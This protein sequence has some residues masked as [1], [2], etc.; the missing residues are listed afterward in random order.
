MLKRLIILPLLFASFLVPGKQI[1]MAISYN[2]FMTPEQEGYVELY[3]ALNSASLDYEK[4]EGGFQS[5][6]EVTI[7]IMQDSTFITGDKFRILSPLYKD[8]SS[9][10]RVLV[11]QQRYVLDSGNYSFHFTIQDIVEEEERHNLSQPIEVKIKREDVFCS[12]I[13]L[14]DDFHKTTEPTA[15]SKSG[16]DLV[17]RITSGTHYLPSGVNEL[18]FYAELYNINQQVND[19]EAFL[20]R[21]YLTDAQSGQVKNSYASFAKKDAQSVVPVLA[22][23]NIKNLPT[24]NYHLTI[25]ASDREGKELWK[26]KLF[27]YRRNPRQIDP[28]KE[29][30]NVDLQQTFA[31]R[32]TEFDSI[33]QY[34]EYLWPIS[35]EKQRNFQ[36]HLLESRDK[37][38]MQKYFYSFWQSQD[39]NNP[40]KA[41]QNYHQKIKKVNHS[42]GTRL[43]PGYMTD[44]GRVYLTYGAPYEIAR[45]QIEPTVPPYE[46]WQYDRINTRFSAPQ[47]N[48]I[49]VFAEY[50]SSTNDY[51]LIHSNAYGEMSNRRWRNELMK[52]GPGAAPNNIDDTRYGSPS[53]SRWGSRINDNIIMGTSGSE[54][55]MR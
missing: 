16:Y 36:E 7:E 18:K 19:G 9:L 48:R 3:F 22:S 44:R 8:T 5:G 35:N 32:Y 37:E 39:Q 33:Y 45:R 55:N 13:M 4:K 2:Q 31:S 24:G 25:E 43:K 30:E 26:E 1:G 6:I 34:I 11:H 52:M 41:W 49:F 14:L 17:P 27:F 53:D 40:A 15:F 50:A 51:S 21:H 28:E 47:N 46:I 38:R 12:E 54:R 29:L 10:G 20:V 42:F 23:Y